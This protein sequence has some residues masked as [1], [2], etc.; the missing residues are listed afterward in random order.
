M[1]VGGGSRDRTAADEPFFELDGC[2][3]MMGLG[4][5]VVVVER[6]EEWRDFREVSTK[7]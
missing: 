7:Q 1:V 4:R 2:D 5:V 3:L 6:T